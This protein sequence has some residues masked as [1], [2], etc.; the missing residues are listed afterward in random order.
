MSR[1]SFAAL[2]TI[3]VAVLAAPQPSSAIDFVEG[4]AS[5]SYAQ[6]STK[7]GKH[8]IE[9]SLV[10]E[11]PR[12]IPGAFLCGMYVNNVPASNRGRVELRIRVVRP[13]GTG[14]SDLT[15][16]KVQNNVASPPCWQLAQGLGKGDVV[17]FDFTMTKFK[18]LKR[19]RGDRFEIFA[20]VTPDADSALRALESRL[21]GARAGE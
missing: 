1:Y 2:T 20:T 8:P 21:A 7:K 12:A 9:A 18:K 13:N 4:A 3:L 19:P 14:G 15:R 6:R 17:T 5:W 11:A 16:T 10:I